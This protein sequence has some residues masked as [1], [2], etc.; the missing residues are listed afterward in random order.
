MKAMNDGSLAGEVINFSRF[1]RQQGFKSFFSGVMESLQSL[2][3]INL[4]KRDEM[5]HALRS[6][7]TTNEME[8]RL[9][10]ELFDQYWQVTPPANKP[11]DRTEI[12]EKP[13]SEKGLEEKKAV[14]SDFSDNEIE[15]TE[16]VSWWFDAPDSRGFSPVAAMEKKDLG[17]IRPDDV[18]IAQLILKNMMTTFRVDRTRRSRTSKKKGEFDFR[19][20]FSKSLKSQG[21]PLE[22]YYQQKKKR[23]KRLVVL[24]DVSGSMDR[25]AKFV[26]PFIL[27]LKGIGSKA[28]VF[29]FSTS[30]TPITFL[31]KHL[32]YEKAIKRIAATVPDWSGGTKIGLS[33]HQFNQNH[34]ARLLHSRTVIVIMSDGWDLG[35]KE[36]LRREM[37][38]IKRKAYSVIWLNP[39]AGGPN[40]RPVPT[41]MKIALP[42]TDYFLP[43]NSLESLRRVGRI[44]SRVMNN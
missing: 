38:N 19:R 15:K 4:D 25:Y 43:A 44:L 23:L 24:A 21:I 11:P 42:Y 18:Q 28:E 7:M 27:G 3:A 2:E 41:G 20:I 5:F 40:F 33:L 12:P 8:W 30:L 26:M 16:N 37:E 36:I 6:N 13:A 32:S 29:V 9:F 31:V 17:T 39:L 22:L 35:G 1:L 34:G 14:Q 10:S